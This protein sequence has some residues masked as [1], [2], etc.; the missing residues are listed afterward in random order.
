[1]QPNQLVPKPLDPEPTRTPQLENQGDFL[2]TGFQLRRA[3]R[4]S[5]VTHQSSDALRL[6]ARQP[7]A[8]RRARDSA[9]AAHEA[10]IL[11]LLVQPNP[12]QTLPLG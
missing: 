5:T 11:F 9:A 10:G 12:R 1:M 3:A 7:F 6:I 4:A 2:G 8:Q